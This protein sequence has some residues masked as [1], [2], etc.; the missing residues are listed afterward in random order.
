MSTFTAM[1]HFPDEWTR[2]ARCPICQSGFLQI[3][4][5]NPKPN[6]IFCPNCGISFEIEKG[7]EHILLMEMPLNFP[8]QL[9]HQWVTRAQIQAILRENQKSSPQLTIPASSGVKNVPAAN[10][11]RADAVRRARSLVEMGNPP[12]VIRKALAESLNLTEFAIEEILND[13]VAVNKNKQN[14]KRKKA[15]IW[16]AATAACLLLGFIVLWIVF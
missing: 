5:K 1:Q 4:R 12:D 8:E 10:P 16:L 14:Q 9:A 11:L 13:A 7:G 2:K 6:Q 15:L 3:R